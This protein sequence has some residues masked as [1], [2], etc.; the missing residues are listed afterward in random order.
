M[1]ILLVSNGFPP[2]STHGTEMYTYNLARALSDAGHTVHVFFPADRGEAAYT[3]V[4]GQYSGIPYTAMQPQLRPPPDLRYSYADRAIDPIFMYLVGTFNPDV[5]HFTYVLIGLSASLVLACRRIGLPVVITTTDAV[6]PCI[7]GQL[8]DIDGAHCPGPDGGRRCATVCFRETG[9]PL[10]EEATP[11]LDVAVDDAWSPIYDRM[12][13]LVLRDRYL[14][15]VLRSADVVVAPTPWMRDVLM[16]W[17]IPDTSIRQAEYGIDDSILCGY[18][19]RPADHLRIGYIGQLLPHKGPQTLFAAFRLCAAPSVELT[20]Y[21]DDQYAPAR[22]FLRSLVRD[23]ADPRI[24]F[25]GTFPHDQIAAVLG[26]IDVLV[27][28]SIWH[29]NSPLVLRNAVATDTPVIVADMEGMRPYV[30]HLGNGLLFEAGN[31][32]DLYLKL[33]YVLDNPELLDRFRRYHIPTTTIAEDASGLS[34]VYASLIAS[35]GAAGD[36][37]SVSGSIVSG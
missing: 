5:V 35:R 34:R 24:H 6:F 22:S 15:T 14:R 21:G 16:A 26:E 1:R 19:H 29:E 4:A 32:D 12:H 18:V 2:F 13:P 7:R 30:Q 31:V 25:R 17:G 9:W 33:Q 23:T 27:V 11:P 36:Q 28:P 3:T 8:L 37:V 10:D 20:V